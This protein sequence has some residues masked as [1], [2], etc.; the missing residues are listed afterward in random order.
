LRR[1]CGWKRDAGIVAFEFREDRL[2]AVDDS[3][4]E[5]GEARDLNAVAAVGGAG[6]DA[7]SL[8]CVKTH[9]GCV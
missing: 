4:R 6:D 3:E 1:R 9:V 5:A 8:R 2:R 7:G